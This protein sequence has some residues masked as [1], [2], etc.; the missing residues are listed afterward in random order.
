MTQSESE[1]APGASR[2]Q[3]TWSRRDFAHAALALIGGGTWGCSPRPAPTPRALPPYTGP[4]VDPLH[5]P[6]SFLWEQRVT[7]Y[8]DERSGGFDAVIQKQGDQLLVLGLTPMGTRGFSIRQQGQQFSY[9]QFVPFKLPF[10]PEAVLIDIH[11]AFFFAL[12]ERFP[13]QGTRVS[14]FKNERV[15]D[16]FLKNHLISRTF[17]RVS[18][19]SGQ[20]TVSYSDKGYLGGSPPNLT[21]LHNEA[22]GYRLTVE[23]RTTQELPPLP[24]Q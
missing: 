12:I 19:T 17:E 5:I 20:L 18:G 1:R 7:A 21:S 24:P 14:S 16:V 6:G 15:R 23:T 4:L 2:P 13:H 10:S 22:Y 8:H 9:E 3:V 11:R